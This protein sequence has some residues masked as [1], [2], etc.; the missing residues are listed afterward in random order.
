MSGRK[1]SSVTIVFPHQL[2]KKHPALM[3]G[4]KVVLVEEW[5]FFNQYQ[6]IK[7]KLVMHRASMM[8]Y[9][10]WLEKEHKV[11]YIE[12]TEKTCDIRK[13][14]AALAKDGV[15]EIHVAE[16]SDDWLGRRLTKSAKRSGVVLH[17][18]DNP[19]FLNAAEDAKE[20]LDGRKGYFMADFYK[21]QRKKRGILVTPDGEP[22]EANGRLM[23]RT[24]RS[25]R[26]TRNCLHC[27]F[28]S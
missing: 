26:K 10:T 1:E 8:F 23:K 5:L 13:L 28:Q 19:G 4:R 15:E 14:V 6:F 11:D 24:E 12:A 18:Y 17:V 3:L 21:W 27:L 20:Y 2:F 22:R 16:V 25:C 9:K 7:Q